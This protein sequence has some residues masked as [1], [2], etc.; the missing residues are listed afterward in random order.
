MNSKQINVF[1]TAGDQA[2]LIGAFNDKVPFVVVHPRSHDGEVNRLE[3]AQIRE[4]GKDLLK[5]YFVQPRHIDRIKFNSL[6]IQTYKVVDT[7]RSPVVEFSRCFHVGNILRR[8]RLYFVSSYYGEG[9]VLKKKPDDFLEWA[10]AFLSISRKH[11]KKDKSGSYYVGD[12]A[13]A[14]KAAGTQFE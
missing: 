8:G 12:N 10:D 11:L 9:S 6:K 14:L 7:V 13:L 1:L 3:D 2:A 5:I 4:M